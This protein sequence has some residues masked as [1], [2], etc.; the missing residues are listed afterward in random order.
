MRIAVF[1]AGGIGG[2]F[3]ERLAAGGADVHLIARG[4]HLEAIRQAG[5]TI[6]TPEGETTRLFP[7][8]SDPTEIGPVDVVLFCVKSYD[9]D[10]A[11]VTLPPLLH[12]RTAVVSLQ[13]GVDNEERIAAAVG[14]PHVVGGAAY[15]FAAIESPGVIRASGPRS[16]VFGEWDGGS[17]SQRLSDLAELFRAAEV[18][19]RTSEDV[20][21]AI[22]EKYVLLVAFSGLSAATRLPLG[23]I[24]DAPAAWALLRGLANEAWQV[25]RAYGVPLGDDVVDT[26][27]GILG[28][29]EGGAYASLFHD[30]VAGHR[31]ELEA[32]QGTL[33]RLGREH[34]V[35]T[36]IARAIHGVLEPWARRNSDSSGRAWQAEAPDS[37]AS[38]RG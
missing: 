34:G 33:V 6:R 35:E 36:P 1:G 21:T 26:A 15:I 25:G 24:R 12:D 28:R 3:G 38:T 8:T 30:L 23:E 13:N 4:R 5:L 17:P 27:V 2:Y 7:A 14:W 22:W 37:V 10:R 19:A 32:L 20:R 31:M 29:Q 11:A 18:D 16:L 9:T